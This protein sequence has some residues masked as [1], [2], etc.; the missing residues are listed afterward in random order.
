MILPSKID[1]ALRVFEDVDDREHDT[2]VH[3]DYYLQGHPCWEVGDEDGWP[4]DL[5]GLRR[6]P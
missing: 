4:R 5:G 2:K 6:A 3:D 1:P